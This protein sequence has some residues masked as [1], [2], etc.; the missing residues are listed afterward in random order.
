M[1]INSLG[2]NQTEI[3]LANDTVI[4]IAYQTPVAAF[5][6]GTGIVRTEHKW[7]QTTTRYINKWI[8]DVA[9]LATVSTRPQS[10]FDALV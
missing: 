3:T 1:K 4:F 9:P 10:F 6:P 5:I 7:P 2:K 8:A